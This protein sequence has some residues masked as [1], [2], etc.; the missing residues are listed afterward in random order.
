MGEGTS[1]NSAVAIVIVAIVALPLLLVGS[2]LG[3]GITA[4]AA[5][6]TVACASPKAGTVLP[7]GITL[8]TEQA[9]NAGTI[10]SVVQNERF[11]A[12]AA[13]A[14]LS[15]A[16]VESSLVNLDHGDSDSLG[17]FQERP[18][19][20]WG[21]PLQ[22]MDPLYA[23]QVWLAHMA[24]VPNWESLAPDVIAQAVE[25]SAYPA[26]YT[27]QVAS[28]Q[29]LLGVGTTC[30]GQQNVPTLPSSGD[31]LPAGYSIPPGATSQEITAVNYVTGQLG[32]PYVYGG[33]GTFGASGSAV[34][35]IGGYIDGNKCSAAYAAE[36]GEPGFDCSGLMQAAWAAAGVTIDRT[37]YS[38]VSDGT[39]VASTVDL[40]PGDLIFIP[41]SDAEGALPGHVGMYIGDGLL[42]D[43]P[44]TGVTVTVD[45][46]SN[47]ANQVDGMRHIV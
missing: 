12:L 2:V 18:S 47:W 20:G 43:A 19:Q 28:A 38:Q 24:K 35:C 21:T 17:L 7:D 37:T 36:A 42:V 16:L 22:I 33:G 46:V 3:L 11:D 8:S 15:A 34:P 4:G 27:D 1:G 13:T 14:A 32:K 31:S 44:Y 9:D 29:V 41:G 45:T 39:A 40:T 5:A 26:R 6:S 23:T 10:I 25:V 30:T